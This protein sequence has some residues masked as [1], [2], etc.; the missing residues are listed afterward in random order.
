[1][2]ANAQLSPAAW[3]IATKAA[4]VLPIALLTA[5]LILIGSQLLFARLFEAPSLA[6]WSPAAQESVFTLVCFGLLIGSAFGG[7][8]LFGERPSV[9]PRPLADGAMGFALGMCGLGA[10]LGLAALAGATVSGGDAG[11]LMV[12]GFA[13]AVVPPIAEE[14]IFRGW[15][16]PILQAGWGRW[17]GLVA[18]S[19]AFA[20]AHFLSGDGDPASMLNLLLGG[21]WFG[22]LADRSGG[23]LLPIGA[24]YGWNAAEELLFGVSPNP[25]AGSFGALFDWDLTGSAFWGGSEA[26]LNA[27]LSSSF[28]LLALIVATAGWQGRVSPLGRRG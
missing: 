5:A 10:A 18:T 24:H 4:L 20:G 21:L 6:A 19:A 15:I 14:L 8:S 1:M 11:S 26:G 28:A 23:L 7:T 12:L 3:T 16:Q 13:V 25:G 27:S 2:A 9:G 17:A 22:L